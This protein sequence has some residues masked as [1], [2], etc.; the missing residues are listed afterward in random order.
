MSTSLLYHGFG[1]RGYNDLRTEDVDGGVVFEAS[2]DE[3]TTAAL[4]AC[5]RDSI[6]S[7]VMRSANSVKLGRPPVSAVWKPDFSDTSR[8][9]SVPSR[10]WKFAV[11]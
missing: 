5:V 10:P 1:I 7:R 6:D 3:T 8:L 11:P 4:D 9:I 2:A